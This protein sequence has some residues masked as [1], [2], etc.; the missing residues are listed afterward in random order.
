MSDAAAKP[1]LRLD[2]W[3]WHARACRTRSAATKLAGSGQVRLNGAVTTKAH[4]NLRP[5]D[6]L[7]FPQGD[8][9]RVWRVAALAERRGSATVA[10]ALYEDLKPP[11]AENRL[12]R[13]APRGEG[14]PD[15]RQRRQR[16]ALAGKED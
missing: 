13:P 10:Q 16:R 1:S 14:R 7:T 12:P 4:A 3:L 5:G 15:S 8:H 2:K 11:T 9:I 6:V